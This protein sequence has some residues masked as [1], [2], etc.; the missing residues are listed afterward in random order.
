MVDDNIIYGSVSSRIS[1]DSVSREDIGNRVRYL[2]LET[3]SRRD[4]EILLLCGS[5]IRGVV[6]E[7]DYFIRQTNIPRSI[8]SL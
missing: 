7:I 5:K 4:T 3:V 1:G 2:E 8:S 6:V